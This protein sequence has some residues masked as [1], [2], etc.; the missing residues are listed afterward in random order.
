VVQNP[1]RAVSASFNFNVS[2]QGPGIFTNGD[3]FTVPQTRCGRGETCILFLTGQG[4]VSPSVDTGAAPSP[5]GGV[6]GLPRPA[7]GTSMSIG[8]V[9]AGIAFAGIPPG[10]VGV[11]QIN[12]TVSPST[13]VGTQPVIVKVGDVQSEAARIEIF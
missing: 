10:L 13:P 12:F 2:A 3:R 4:A 5:A 1:Q 7:A 8:G 9:E 11:M 6:A